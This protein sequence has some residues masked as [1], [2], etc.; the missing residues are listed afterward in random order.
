M[1]TAVARDNDGVIKW[2]SSLRLNVDFAETSEAAA[3]C[4]AISSTNQPEKSDQGLFFEGDCAVIFFNFPS[5]AS[6]CSV[7][8]QVFFLDA[9]AL[10]ESVK[11]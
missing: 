7:D 2:I 4:L 3:L 10:L 11:L 8:S 9:I 6:L 1:A 5:R